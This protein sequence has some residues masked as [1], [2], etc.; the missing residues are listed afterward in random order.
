MDSELDIIAERTLTLKSAGTAKLITVQIGRPYSEAD[1]TH[2]CPYK[3]CGIPPERIRRAGGVDGI[4]ALQLALVKIGAELSVHFGS[5]YWNESPFVGLPEGI[6]DSVVG[7]D[8]AEQPQQVKSDAKKLQE[9]SAGIASFPLP[10]PDNPSAR[11]KPV[12]IRGEPLSVTLLRD[13]GP[14]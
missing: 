4:H 2:F 8:D 1:G 9:D 3:V 5:L 10:T 11:F 14:R 13:R 12:P 7:T 6:C